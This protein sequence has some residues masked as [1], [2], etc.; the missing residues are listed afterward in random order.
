MK[1]WTIC[2]KECRSA[3]IITDANG[4]HC[5]DCD[6]LELDAYKGKPKEVYKKFNGLSFWMIKPGDPIKIRNNHYCA[7]LHGLEGTACEQSDQG[8]GYG[9]ALKV[10]VTLNGKLYKTRISCES[11]ILLP[12]E[13]HDT[14]LRWN[15]YR[16][17][18]TTK[19]AK[20]HSTVRE[21]VLDSGPEVSHSPNG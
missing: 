8:N 13:E 6:C 5:G 19:A 4:T 1:K 17:V 2:C 11:L 14:P 7:E 20:D 15:P 10:V 3:N 9:A 18:S 12:K 21:S 16:G